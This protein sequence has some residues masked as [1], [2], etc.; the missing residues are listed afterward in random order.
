MP[1]SAEALSALHACEHALHQLARR[2]AKLPERIAGLEASAQAARDVIAKGREELEETERLRREKEAE[3]QD[4][5]AQRDKFRGQTANVKTN[6]EYTALLS[7]IDQVDAR[8]SRVEEEILTAME[9]IE[10]LSAALE[11]TEREQGKAAQ[12]LDD[13]AKQVAEELKH[14]HVDAET[15][16]AELDRRVEELDAQTRLL[17]DRA[18]KAKGTGTTKLSGRVCA[19]CHRDVPFDDINRV[20]GGQILPCQSCRRLLVVDPDA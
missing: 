4:C 12:D 14:V 17:F 16:S 10:E 13:R 20:I 19:S 3:L 11:T 9:R 5:E 15:R 2:Q 8:I 6:P 7:E 18:R 1:V